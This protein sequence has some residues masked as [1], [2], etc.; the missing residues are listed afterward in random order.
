MCHI[1]STGSLYPGY[2]G[3]RKTF[4]GFMVNYFNLTLPIG[5]AFDYLSLRISMLL[6]G[7]ASFT[8]MNSIPFCIVWEK[9]DSAH[10]SIYF[11]TPYT[12]TRTD[13]FVVILFLNVDV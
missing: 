8:K 11:S 13:T 7:V 12:G 6:S 10:R 5:I 9:R 3:Y 2:S 1:F 4:I